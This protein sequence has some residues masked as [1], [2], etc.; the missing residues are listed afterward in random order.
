MDDI[1]RLE[2]ERFDKE[3]ARKESFLHSFL[4]GVCFAKLDCV[5]KHLIQGEHKEALTVMND[6][7]RYIKSEIEKTY[8]GND[9]GEEV[10][11][12]K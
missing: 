4:V 10:K 3:R 1:T 7:M 11:N 9:K 5:H 8:Y 2:C 12:A 6:A